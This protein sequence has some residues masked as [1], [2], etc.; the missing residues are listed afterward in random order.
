MIKSTDVCISLDPPIYV[1]RQLMYGR[2]K[3]TKNVDV[4]KVII[5][6]SLPVFH[7][8]L[9]L[10]SK[11]TFRLTRFKGRYTGKYNHEEQMVAINPNFVWDRVLETIAHELVHAEQYNENR[12]K[13]VWRS[14]Q[15]WVYQ[16]NGEI[17]TNKG[18][19]YKS[20][21]KQPWE[22]EA[23]SRQKPLADQ[24]CEILDK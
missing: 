20:Y 24:V 21:R 23:F 10:P 9:N 6:K 1:S 15:G 18:S 14:R 3:N 13:S 7:K 22:E 19:T 16:W 2:L 11:I 12:L 5:Q 8:L 17:N 4:A